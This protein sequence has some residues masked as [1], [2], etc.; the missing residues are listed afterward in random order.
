M[1]ARKGKCVWINP[2]DGQPYARVWWYDGLGIRRERRKRAESR[3]HAKDLGDDMLNEIRLTAGRSLEH[4][5][6]TFAELAEFYE[7]HYC[8]PP[9]YVQGRK[10]AGLRSHVGVRSNLKPLIDHFGRMRVR[11]IFY[12]HLRAYKL[13]RLRTKTKYESERSIASVQRE[14]ALMRRVLNIAKRNG[15]IIAS[16]FHAGESL[17][18]LADENERMRILTK[19]EAARLLLEACEAED[20]NGRQRCK[21]LRP[22]IIAALDTALRKGELLKLTWRDV[23]FGLGLINVKAMNTKT[24]RPRVVPLT[25][26]LHDELMSLWEASEQNLSARLFGITDNVKNSFDTARTLA[27]LQDVRFH[28]LRHTAITWMLEA[29]TPYAKVMKISGHTSLKTFLRYVNVDA[30]TARTAAILLDKWH[31]QDIIQAEEGEEIIH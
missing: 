6:T 18:S 25:S 20:K 24:M 16:P 26:R 17:I 28:D 12:E 7:Q 31:G 22:V 2:R 8:Q 14:L 5:H 15:W 23:D 27:G 30:E 1:S 9:E 13:K 21:H 29:G 10:I 4:Y 3:T 11:S 19:A